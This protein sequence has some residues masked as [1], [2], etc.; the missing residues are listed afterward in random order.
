LDFSEI[1]KESEEVQAG[2]FIELVEKVIELLSNAKH[3]PSDNLTIKGNLVKLKAVGEALIIGDLHGDL[4]SLMTILSR[5]KFLEKME[6]NKQASMIFLGDYGDR[7]SKSPELYYAVL[8][9]K[10]AYPKQ[11]VLLRG[12]HEG[13]SNLL[14]SPHDLPIYLHRKFEEKWTAVYRILREL[15]GYLF[16]AVYVE[17]RYLI[18]HGGLPSNIRSL[19][20]IA[21]VDKFYPE[22]TF[23]EEFLWNDPSN[24]NDGVCPS[25]RGAGNLFGKKVTEDVLHK[26]GVKILI[27]G[28]EP[29]RDGF[30][31]THGGKILTLFSCKGPPYFNRYGA[32][33][34]LP[35]EEDCDNAIQLLPYVHKF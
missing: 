33:L 21:E 4:P 5:S 12:N 11:V 1:I 17:K 7:G 16:I 25:P 28:H 35:L 32:Y 29:A 10:L 15:F 3:T 20:E 27:R 18:V 9:L 24:Q 30:A 13:P 2:N 31:L 19:Q 23:L 14:A 34:D 6:T 22:K 26:L 8:N